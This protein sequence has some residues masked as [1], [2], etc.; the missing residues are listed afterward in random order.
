MADI[1]PLD[2]AH[3]MGF[4]IA[5]SL[6]GLYIGMV[7]RTIKKQWANRA[8]APVIAWVTVA[9]LVL[10]GTVLIVVDVRT[11]WINHWPGV[12]NYFL[13][14][15]TPIRPLRAL[16]LALAGIICD[17]LLCWRLYVI[18][19]SK[20]SV[21][22]VPALLLAVE[23]ISVV[24]LVTLS[25]KLRI[26]NDTSTSPNHS[27]LLAAAY[28]AGVCVALMNITCTSLIIVRLFK[29]GRTEGRTNFETILDSFV[30]SGALFTLTLLSWLLFAVIPRAN[31]VNVF[32][33]YVLVMVTPITALLIAIHLT[34][35]LYGNSIET[36]SMGKISSNGNTTRRHR[37]SLPKTNFLSSRGGGTQH[38]TS[39][40]PVVVNVQHET[41]RSSTTEPS[42]RIETLDHHRR[43]S[44]RHFNGTR[45]SLS[46]PRGKSGGHLMRVP[47]E[48][49]NEEYQDAN[50]P[51]R[52]LHVVRVVQTENGQDVD[53]EKGSYEDDYD[54]SGVASNDSPKSNWFDDEEMNRRRE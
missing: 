14:S 42:V 17:I 34:E 23:T 9:L 35:N 2:V 21:I 6:Y 8:E 48:S 13:L 7:I 46:S 12:A 24:V 3:L 11:A 31:G 40:G 39:G 4:L 20:R 29:T 32:F 25:F 37:S 27:S 22:I 30:E 50:A 26:P 5:M 38:T 15:W 33:A 41:Y 19:D 49:G 54:E 43:Q 1:L 10:I 47:L 45:K 44:Q 51:Q 16:F 28:A 18:W 53:I 52:R 36:I